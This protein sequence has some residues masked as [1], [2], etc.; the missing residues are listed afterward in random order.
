MSDPKGRNLGTE[1][2]DVYLNSLYLRAE[3]TITTP[4]TSGELS[5]LNEFEAWL[6]TWHPKIYEKMNS[7]SGKFTPWGFTH[8]KLSLMRA[9]DMHFAEIESR[10]S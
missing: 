2:S 8:F 6:E 5:D 1:I 10:W 9:Y 4:L 7:F 3:K